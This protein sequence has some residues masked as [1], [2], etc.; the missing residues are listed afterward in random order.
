[1]LADYIYACIAVIVLYSFRVNE[2]TV[3]DPK[4]F[5]R[6]LTPL[7]LLHIIIAGFLLYNYLTNL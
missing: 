5:N 4:E 6:I 3:D 1:M 2:Y 7:Y